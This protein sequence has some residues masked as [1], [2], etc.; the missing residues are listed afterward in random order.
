MNNSIMNTAR[1]WL[2]GALLAERSLIAAS[3]SGEQ[4]A[5]AESACGELLR[6]TLSGLG[7][8]PCCGRRGMTRGVATVLGVLAVM[9]A[10]EGGSVPCG[11]LVKSAG[12]DAPWVSKK[13]RRLL[14][15]PGFVARLSRTAP[16]WGCC[17]QALGL[18]ARRA[19][20]AQARDLTR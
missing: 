14:P 19:K 2:G 13:R 9:G 7:G 3:N 6:S 15:S 12:C 20:C 8:M 16:R 17:A 18:R 5:S 4:R 1:R 11:T 10:C